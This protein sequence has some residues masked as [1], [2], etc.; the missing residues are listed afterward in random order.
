[1]LSGSDPAW[2]DSRSGAGGDQ[3]Y[4][5]VSEAPDEPRV[6]LVQGVTKVTYSISSRMPEVAVLLVVV[7]P[8][9]TEVLRSDNRQ[10][11]APPEGLVRWRLGMS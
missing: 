3:R 10:L 4:S 11:K 7:Q 2:S 6:M 9:T 1:M 5:V 8:M